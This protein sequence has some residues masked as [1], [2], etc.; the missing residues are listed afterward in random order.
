MKKKWLSTVLAFV[1]VGCFLFTSC[2][3]KGNESFRENS[4]VEQENQTPQTD[5]EKIRAT[6]A[7]FVKVYNDGD[8]EA[9]LSCLEPKLRNTTRSLFNVLGGVAGGLLGVDVSF[10]DLFTLGIGT[11]GASDWMSV[12]IEKIEVGVNGT[13]V[14]TKTT[15]R[16]DCETTYFLMVQEGDEW[17]IAD[18][19]EK[20]PS[21]APATGM[22]IMACRSFYGDVAAIRYAL[23]GVQY[24][25]LLNANGSIVYSQPADTVGGVYELT[26]G[27]TMWLVRNEQNEKQ[28]KLINKKGEV[29]ATYGSEEF[30]Y[31]KGAGN[32][33]VVVYKKV[34]DING[35][36]HC[37]GIIDKMGN[38]T[39][40]L[41]DTGTGDF[42]MTKI[43]FTKDN[44][45]IIYQRD[46]RSVIFNLKT[47]QQ[48]VLRN[49]PNFYVCEEI[50][51]CLYMAN[52]GFLQVVGDD[53]IVIEDAYFRVNPD[54]TIT[55]VDLDTGIDSLTGN[56]GIYKDKE[57]GNTVVYNIIAQEKF[58]Y[59]Q[60]SEMEKTFTYIGDYFLVEIQGLNREMYFTVLDMNGVQQFEPIKASAAQYSEGYIIA[61]QQASNGDVYSIVVDTKGNVMMAE[62][63]Y[64][65]YYDGFHNGIA[66]ALNVETEEQ[67][68]IN[69]KGEVVFENYYIND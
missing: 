41:T 25:G 18:I 62:N 27:N 63:K 5:E 57:N 58:E 4:Q 33:Y 17:L 44:F 50:D 40:P 7:K 11:Q 3:K 32:G 35:I 24:S 52:Q 66:T 12:E 68:Y 28:Y 45:V 6:I 22:E 10:S 31:I 43:H 46:W 42:L 59:S 53:M 39:M 8:F 26:D 67:L 47:K 56:Y 16:G 2:D 37:Y 60:Y 15:F 64:R 36:R 34:S 30:D 14:T 23:D 38:W 54:C 61:E 19:T 13:R 51:G 21:I 48:L 20:K 9:F 55:G 1:G 29:V 49:S 65:I 69:V